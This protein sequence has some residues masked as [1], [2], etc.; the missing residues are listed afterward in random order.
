MTKGKRQI[1][2]DKRQKMKDERQKTI[3]GHSLINAAIH[4]DLALQL[5]RPYPCFRWVLTFGLPCIHKNNC[6]IAN[7]CNN[8]WELEET[9]SL[10]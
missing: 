7:L 8:K 3:T 6:T 9:F 2:K 5:R 10:G 1:T 4:D